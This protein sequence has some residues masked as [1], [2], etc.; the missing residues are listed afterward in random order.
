MDSPAVQLGSAETSR[1]SV[2]HSLPLQ[3]CSRTTRSIVAT[4][5]VEESGLRLEMMWIRTVH[6]QTDNFRILVC[7]MRRESQSW[8]FVD[9]V[10]EPDLGFVACLMETRRAE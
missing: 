7:L 6:H 4:A 9:P 10:E 2:P 3:R 8:K 1:I 5:V